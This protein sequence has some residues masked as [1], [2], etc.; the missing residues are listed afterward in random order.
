[1]WCKIKVLV[2]ISI[3][4]NIKNYLSKWE[5]LNKFVLVYILIIF[6]FT[7]FGCSITSKVNYD[8]EK[9]AMNGSVAI[10]AVDDNNLNKTKIT[11]N[12]IISG[13]KEDINSIYAQEPLINVEYIDLILENGPHNSQIKGIENPYLEITGSFVFD[14]TGKSKE[15]IDDM[16]FSSMFSL[17]TNPVYILFFAVNVVIIQKFWTSLKH[18]LMSNIA[19]IVV[20]VICIIVIAVLFLTIGY[21]SMSIIPVKIS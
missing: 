20:F 7:L 12:V 19:V 17:I 2:Y 13:R 3:I 8:N 6:A 4:L 1:M 21:L 11:Y 14:T 5:I 10:G 18:A 16:C 15:E 9:F